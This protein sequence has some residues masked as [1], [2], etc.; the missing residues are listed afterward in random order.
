MPCAQQQWFSMYCNCYNVGEGSNQHKGKS[1]AL[2]IEKLI[3]ILPW[4]LKHLS[5]FRFKGE[6]YGN[7]GM[8]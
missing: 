1:Y 6:Q 8:L 4:Q 7:R 2:Q 3:G 5:A